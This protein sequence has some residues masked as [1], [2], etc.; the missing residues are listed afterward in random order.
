MKTKLFLFLTSLAILSACKDNSQKKSIETAEPEFTK[1]AEL[2]FVKSTGTG[3]TL[4]LIFD[5]EIAKTPFEQSTGLMYRKSMKEDR[6]MLF[7][8]E[9]ERPRGGFYMKNTYI[10]LDL[11]YIGSD[12]KI[13]DFNENTEPFN[14]AP[15]PSSAPAQYVLEVNAGVVDKLGLEVGDGMVYKEL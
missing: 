1:E 2:F 4:D 5:I 7:V 13:V 10:A 9:N 14:E 8:Y 3:D 6:G 11:I 12:D 15:V